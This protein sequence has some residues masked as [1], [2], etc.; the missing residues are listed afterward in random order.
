MLSRITKA[1]RPSAPVAAAT[2]P[3]AEPMY[4]AC[5]ELLTLA[6]SL[7]QGAQPP[8]DLPRHVAGMLTAMQTRARDAGIPPEDA[9][10]AMFPI[11]AL[12]DEILVQ[13]PWSGQNQWRSQ[14]LQFQHFKENSAGESFFARVDALLRQPHRAHVLLIYFYVLALGFHGRYAIRGGQGLEPIYDAVANALAPAMPPSEI[15]SPHGAPTDGGRFLQREAPIVRASLGILAV[16]LL[17]FVVLRLAL[18]LKTSHVQEPMDDFA[19]AAG[20]Q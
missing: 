4:G 2:H 8:D 1:L 13:V 3:L 18:S 15:L 20:T 16:A 5:H 6:A 9:R 11:L 17:L 10:D 14:T 7:G 19:H 12:L